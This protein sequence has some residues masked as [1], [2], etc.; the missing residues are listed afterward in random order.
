M[1]ANSLLKGL[2]Q[3]VLIAPSPPTQGLMPLEDKERRLNNHPSRFNA[4]TTVAKPTQVELPEP[5]KERAIQTHIQAENSAWN[6]WLLDGMNY[7]IADQ[8]KNVQVPM[9]VLA[10]HDDP[11]IPFETI[12]QDVMSLLPKARLIGISGVGL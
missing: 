12:Q 8:M 6:G 9:T 10:S 2:K 4:E 3:I 11:V 1:A 5:R 7:S